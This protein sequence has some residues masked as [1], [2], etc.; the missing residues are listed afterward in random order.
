MEVVLKQYFGYDSF[1]PHQ[2]E[3]IES[4]L[5]GNDN[6]VMMATGS[7][8]SLCY[9]IPPLITG[10]MMVVIS[11][12]VALMQDQVM[13][14]KEA[15]I[16]ATFM[17]SL[18]SNKEITKFKV[19][20]GQYSLVYI[21]PE[22]T[23]HFLHELQ[24]MAENKLICGF[25]IDESHCVSEWGHDFR[26]DYINLGKLRKYCPNVPIIAL[27]ATATTNVVTDIIKGLNMK[28]VK[29]T[30][31]TFNRPNL[32]YHLEPKQ[33]YKIDLNRFFSTPLLDLGSISVGEILRTKENS[34]LL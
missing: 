15:G 29:I 21:T 3:I 6:F 27:T 17:G 14:L 31:T 5:N 28:D 22:K 25:A 18:Q 13:Q 16:S 30:Q 19:M 10:K 11:P 34:S 2:K 7:G 4:L 1:R 12:L 9:Q 26:P 24:T 32:S 23:S 8:K 33:D 20:T